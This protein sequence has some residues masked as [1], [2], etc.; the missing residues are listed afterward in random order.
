MVFEPP[1]AWF[2]CC[3]PPFRAPW[4][5]LWL[6]VQC[7]SHLPESH[8]GPMAAMSG[9]SQ[10]LVYLWILNKCLLSERNGWVIQWKGDKGLNKVLEK[11][12]N[13]DMRD[14]G[15]KNL[16]SGWWGLGG[17]TKDNKVSSQWLEDCLGHYLRQRTQKEGWNGVGV[18]KQHFLQYLLI[19]M[20]FPF[21]FPCYVMKFT[22]IYAS[23]FPS[24]TGKLAHEGQT[25]SNSLLSICHRILFPL[26]K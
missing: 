16:G 6:C 18:L 22:I 14:I 10:S 5:S 13:R 15:R 12:K 4:S 2:T 23:L 7:L 25:E 17:L 1:V 26:F 21:S 20:L 8:A 11:T 19:T 9:M 24:S 3:S